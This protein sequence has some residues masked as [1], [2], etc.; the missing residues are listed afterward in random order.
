MAP[1]FRAVPWKRNLQKIPE[2][3][4]AQARAFGSDILFVGITKTLAPNEIEQT[5]LRQ[6]G[7]PQ[8][9]GEVSEIIPADDMGKYSRR[10]KH[11]WEVVRDDLPKITKTQ[12]WESPNFG[13]AS[14]YGTHTHYW[15]REVYQREIHEPRFYSIQAKTVKV[16]AAGDRVVLIRLKQEISRTSRTFEDEL[17]FMLNLL[18]ENCG[19]AEVVSSET[20]EA[21]YIR[22][23]NLDWEVFP[24]GNAGEVI[25]RLTGGRSADMALRGKVEERVQ[26]FSRLTPVAYLKGA[27]GFGS[28]IGAKYADDLVVF[29]NVNYG[30]ALYVLYDNWEDVSKRSRLDLL[31]GTDARFDRLPHRTGWDEAFEKLLRSEK[32]KRGLK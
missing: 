31:K 14:R 13:D 9:E 11:G 25:E 21:D 19:G 22:T 8:A 29:E 5:P 16:N 30:N 10:N 7:I 24:P 12:Y 15:T 1:K 2:E 18:Q 26:L 20:A 28:Y 23:I 6:L 32:R 3:L 17:L 27:A 4:L